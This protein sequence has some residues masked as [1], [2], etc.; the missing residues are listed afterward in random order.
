MAVQIEQLGNIPIEKIKIK[1]RAR[2]DKGDIELLADSLKRLGQI[3]AVVVNKKMELVAGERRILAAKSLGWEDIRAEMRIGQGDDQEAERDENDV[4]KDFTWRERCALERSIYD[5]K[6]K[7]N[8][9]L[10]YEDYAEG[11]GVH[12]FSVRK[13]LY[14]A[15]FADT[16][17]D[18]ADEIESEDEAYKVY[19]ELEEVKMTD[20]LRRNTPE[21]IL[22]APKW[23]EDHYRVGDALEGMA[24]TPDECCEFAEV[25]PPYAIDLVDRKKRQDDDER[26][27]EYDEIE[28]KEYPTFL[29]TLVAHVYR[30]LK[31]NSFA[32]FWYGHQWHCKLYQT[33]V[34]AGFA[35]NTT[36]AI[37][38]KNQAGQTA[39]PDIMLGSSYESFFVARKGKPRMSRRGR[40]NV[41][42][43][44]PLAPSKK[45]HLTEKPLD[46]M[47]DILETFLFPGSQVLI[48]FLGSGVTLRAAYHLKHT[49]FGWDKSK[50][51]RE[52]FLKL[53]SEEFKDVDG[54]DAGS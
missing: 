16:F 52:K 46:L 43:F 42:H 54:P 53:V 2:E 34:D 7:K 1:N 8:P 37:W 21:V 5:L 26:K 15:E 23:A 13:R 39:Q 51:H 50:R 24:A 17:P 28:V 4:R 27:D 49:G 14:A 18:L 20:T 32:V 19:K 22:K 12:Q 47:R 48:P 36:P 33:L 31:P 41:F 29:E 10:T 38:Y 6:K 44:A 45:I 25:D 11:R 35:V 30:I 9:A 40:S 3:H